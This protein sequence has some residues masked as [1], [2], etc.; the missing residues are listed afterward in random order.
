M[1]LVFA[2]SLAGTRMSF[3]ETPFQ[4]V[5]RC[6]VIKIQK[7]VTEWGCLVIQAQENCIVVRFPVTLFSDTRI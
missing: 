3:I 7:P 4:N 6:A 2:A 5:L 1:V